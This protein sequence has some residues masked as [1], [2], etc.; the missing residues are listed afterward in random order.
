[1]INTISNTPSNLDR[2]NSAM[3][4]LEANSP[5]YERGELTDTEAIDDLL[6][7]VM[8]YCKANQIDFADRLRIAEIHFIAETHERR[9][10]H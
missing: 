6:S 8:H 2:A 1:M 3:S 5:D 4:A 10:R 7:N 9:A